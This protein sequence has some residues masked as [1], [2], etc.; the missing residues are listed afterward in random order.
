MF[1]KMNALQT[2]Y[3]ASIKDFI[4]HEEELLSRVSIAPRPRT[5]WHGQS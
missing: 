1:T 4:G 5:P 3:I 2:A